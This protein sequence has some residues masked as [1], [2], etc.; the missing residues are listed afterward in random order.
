VDRI[1]GG[2]SISGR[3]RVVGRRSLVVCEQRPRRKK[4]RAERLTTD[5]QRLTYD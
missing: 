2:H 5:D 1:L 3:I 4:K